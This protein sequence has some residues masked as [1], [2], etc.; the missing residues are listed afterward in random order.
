M[1]QGGFLWYLHTVLDTSPTYLP[2]TASEG[3]TE[4]G[5]LWAWPSSAMGVRTEMLSGGV[6]VVSVAGISSSC[7]HR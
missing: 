5:A 6:R 1:T 4:M 3:P 2:T 7:W